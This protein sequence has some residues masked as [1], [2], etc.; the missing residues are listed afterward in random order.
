MSAD[1]LEQ[2]K[3][4]L[5]L[6]ADVTAILGSIVALMEDQPE[7]KPEPLLT[8]EEAEDARRDSTDRDTAIRTIAGEARG[9]DPEVQAAVADVILERYHTN[10]RGMESLYQVCMDP[11]QFSCWN[12]DVHDGQQAYLRSLDSADPAY[13]IAEVALDTAILGRLRGHSI[14]KRS[15]HFHDSSIGFPSAWGAPQEPALV[16]GAMTFYNTVA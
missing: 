4:A 3:R 9:E 2:L 5:A 7:P 14:T 12:Q 15:R 1:A 8:E 13:Q 6:Q 16:L 10:Y 11:W